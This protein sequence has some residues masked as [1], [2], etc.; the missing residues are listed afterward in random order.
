MLRDCK[1][2]N[3]KRCYVKVKRKGAPLQNLDYPIPAQQKYHTINKTSTF[4]MKTCIC[5]AAVCSASIVDNLDYSFQGH[6]ACV[7]VQ[8]QS[9][10]FL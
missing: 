8:A 1:I 2:E 5:L 6:F 7:Q 9:L 4:L 3:D 10:M